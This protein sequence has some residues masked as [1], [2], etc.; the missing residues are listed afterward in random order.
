MDKDFL[1]IMEDF[2]TLQGEGRFSGHAAYFI[3]L[4]GCS[5]GCPFCDVKES[6][7]KKPN[8]IQS[9]QDLVDKTLKSGANIAVITGGEPMEQD[10]S[11][12]TKELNSNLIRTHIE[13]SGSSPLSGNFDWITLSPKRY[14]PSLD[15]YFK[16]CDELKIIINHRNDLRWASELQTLVKPS[17]ETYIQ[18]EWSQRD[19]LLKDCIEFIKTNPQ[20]KLSSQVHKYLNIP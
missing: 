5:V 19:A 1:Y 15:E 3:R 6:W 4:A 18:V 17:C 7:T 9:V 14:K 16:I 2:W 8:Q 11:E 13:T 12:L 20:F 10:L